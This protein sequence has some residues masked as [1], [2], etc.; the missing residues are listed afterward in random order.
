MKTEVVLIGI[1]VLI[2]VIGG[3]LWYKGKC[4]KTNAD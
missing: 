1:G 4:C 2:L 3:G